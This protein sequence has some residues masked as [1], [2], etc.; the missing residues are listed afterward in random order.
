MF[1]GGGGG[2]ACQSGVPR[3][4]EV[5]RGCSGDVPGSSSSVAGC[6]GPVSGFTSMGY[7]MVQLQLATLGYYKWIFFG[8]S[9]P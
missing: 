5:S 8:A 9:L 2:P 4:S 1:G 3:Y 6:S 7:Q